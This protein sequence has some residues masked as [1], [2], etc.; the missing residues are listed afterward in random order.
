MGSLMLTV[1]QISEWVCQW[2]NWKSVN[3]CWSYGHECRVQFLWATLYMYAA[4]GLENRLGLG[5]ARSRS[6]SRLTLV[7]KI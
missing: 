2:K 7:P 1:L 4:L 3:I 5:L 6:W